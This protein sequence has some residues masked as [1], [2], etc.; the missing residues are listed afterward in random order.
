M[1]NFEAA[2]E[3]ACKCS[4]RSRSCISDD[5]VPT[6]LHTI[7]DVTGSSAL[8]LKEATETPCAKIWSSTIPRRH[9]LSRV[10]SSS[11][12]AMTFVPQL[13]HFRA[14]CRCRP[15]TTPVQTCA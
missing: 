7:T 6:L 1:P 13:T 14:A 12:R 2:Q 8:H 10:A 11:G 15:S 9:A 3:W 5:R 4:N